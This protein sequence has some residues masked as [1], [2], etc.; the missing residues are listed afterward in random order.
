MEVV[1]ESIDHV[2][3][4]V[5]GLDIHKVEQKVRQTRDI[6]FGWE[7]RSFKF[8]NS[9]PL[10]GS[11][12]IIDFPEKRYKGEFVEVRITYNTNENG[13]AI[14]WLKPS[15]TAGKVE[16]YLFTQCQDIACRSIAPLQDTPSN[17]MTY[18]ARVR[19]D[20]QF[21]VK[22]SANHTGMTHDAVAKK[23]TYYF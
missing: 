8:N 5:V 12:L 23:K 1:A 7:Q 14:N 4:D 2:V 18:S 21:T 19:V 10:L 16:P 15:Q 17:K 20:E 13:T 11:A 22:M 3:F 9:R 6:D